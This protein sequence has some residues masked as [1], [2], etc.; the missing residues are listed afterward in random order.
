MFGLQLVLLATPVQGADESTYHFNIPRQRADAALTALGQQADTTVIYQYDW[1]KDQTTNRLQ[2]EYSLSTAVAILL[3]NTALNAQLDPA[4][5]L[6]ITNSNFG[7]NQTG[8]GKRKM[9]IQT[10]KRKTLLATLVGVF[11]AGGAAGVHSQ[12][13]AGATFQGIDEVIVTANKREQ[14]LQDT[15]MSISV[16]SSETI[17]KR[18][19]VEM[20]DY[21]SKT[22]GVVYFESGIT[23]RRLV[24][25]GLS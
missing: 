12:E 11:A 21:L 23:N 24:F 5:H 6:I 9:R 2:G 19:M 25:R 10:T 7:N 22:P 1:V 17:E 13:T 15:A 20:R 8:K 14:G 18:G 3:A 4:G 16:L